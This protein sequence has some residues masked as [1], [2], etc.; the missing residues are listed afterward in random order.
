MALHRRVSTKAFAR[1]AEPGDIQ[2][3]GRPQRLWHAGN[4]GVHSI[5]ALHGRERGRVHVGHPAVFGLCRRYDSDSLSLR[6]D[7]SFRLETDFLWRRLF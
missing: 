3:H 2:I 5:P 4:T 7:F 6:Q 1:P